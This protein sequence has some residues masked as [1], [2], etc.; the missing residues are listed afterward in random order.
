L[1]FHNIWDN[2]SHWLTFSW[3]SLTFKVHC[4]TQPGSCAAGPTCRIRPQLFQAA[5]KVGM[6]IWGSNSQHF[7][8]Q[9]DP[10]I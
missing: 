2:P 6:S 8:S 10:Y 3:C 1:I 9:K 5:V 7:L 4:F